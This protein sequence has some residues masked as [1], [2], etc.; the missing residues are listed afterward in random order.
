MDHPQVPSQVGVPCSTLRFFSLT[1]ENLPQ[2]RV[3]C[4]QA[5]SRTQCGGKCKWVSSL[6]GTW[7]RTLKMENRDGGSPAY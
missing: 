7:K 6:A 1:T 4:N 5:E 2:R 3:Q